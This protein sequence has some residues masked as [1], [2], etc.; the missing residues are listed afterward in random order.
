VAGHVR[1]RSSPSTGECFL[2]YFLG[3]GGWVR[4][5]ETKMLQSRYITIKIGEKFIFHTTLLAVV[6]ARDIHKCVVPDDYYI[7]HHVAKP[8]EWRTPPQ[9]YCSNVI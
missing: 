6:R 4:N 1:R 7:M 8:H 2:I 3:W 9:R 5:A